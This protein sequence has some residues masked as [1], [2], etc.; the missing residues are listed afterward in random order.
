MAIHMFFQDL[1]LSILNTVLVPSPYS[2]CEDARHDV[3]SGAIYGS[4]EVGGPILLI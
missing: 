1:L 3:L 2:H 4:A